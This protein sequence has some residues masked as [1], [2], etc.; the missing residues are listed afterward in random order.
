MKFCSQTAAF[1]SFFGRFSLLALLFF[2]H[3]LLAQQPEP[4]RFRAALVAGLT[5]AQID[6]DNLAGWDKPGAQAGGQVAIF[7]NRRHD[8]SVGILFCQ[9]GAQRELVQNSNDQIFSLTLNYVEVPVQWHIKDW[10]VE[11]D[12]EVFHRAQANFGLS[13]ARLMGSKLK[14]EFEDVVDSE[15]FRENDLSAVAGFSFMPNRRWG[16]TFR[17]NHSL[18]YVWDPRV[19]YPQDFKHAWRGKFLSFLLQYSF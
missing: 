5:A 2:S 4:R 8:A 3:D 11:D 1:C 13:Y 18:T 9:R 17:Y 12:G 16:F 10:F 14:N 15:D 6:G 19:K 7:L